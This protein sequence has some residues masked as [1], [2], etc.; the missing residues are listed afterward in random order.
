[1]LNL[2]NYLPLFLREIREYNEIQEAEGYELQNVDNRINQFKQE[3]SVITASSYGL[4]KYEKV[5]DIVVDPNLDT[6][7]VRRTRLLNRF[8]SKAPFTE[9]FLKQQLN[10]LLGENN[11]NYTLDYNNYTLTINITIPGRSLAIELNK[12]LKKII[13]CNILY[14]VNTY[15]ASWRSVKEHFNTWGD[16]RSYTWQQILDGEF[17]Q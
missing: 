14:T 6:L 5:F 4:E 3:I 1:M 17:L 12:T 9:E 13:P 2:G 15:A 16:L 11:W 7:E 10:S 8:T